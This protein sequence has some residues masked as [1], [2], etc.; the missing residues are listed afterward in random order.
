MKKI[1]SLIL[2]AM[3]L[4]SSLATVAFAAESTKIDAQDKTVEAGDEF[5]IVVSMT[6][7]VINA[8]EIE[9]EVDPELTLTGVE[10]AG[11]K[12]GFDSTKNYDKVIFWSSDNQTA[13]NLFTLKVKIAEDAKPGEYY[14][15]LS[16]FVSNND[17]D[18]DS[19][20]GKAVITIEE[21][22]TEHTHTWG[23]WKVTTT[24][25]CMVEG[26]ETRTC[27]CGESETR[28]TGYGAH[29]PGAEWVGDGTNHWHICTV[30]DEPVEVAAHVHGEWKIEDDKIHSEICSICGA[31]YG[32]ENHDWKYGKIVEPIPDEDCKCQDGEKCTCV[33]GYQEW[34]CK[35]CG[36]EYKK[37]IK[38][39]ACVPPTG[40]ISGTVTTGITA[41][42]IVL[43][44]AAAI[45]FKR[46]TAI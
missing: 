20:F 15:N 27:A 12:G 25:T 3:L 10:Y 28:K 24:A 13:E 9:M 8:F 14:I 39:C 26:V 34:T 11:L 19:T 33:D 21:P 42:V 22:E 40:D 1:L 2:V 6:P 37:I 5:T 7:A 35:D 30:C 17:V 46:K 4:V 38:G 36:H 18:L 29:K 45:V 16:G 43:F 41:L 31:K 32:I 23:E 44:S